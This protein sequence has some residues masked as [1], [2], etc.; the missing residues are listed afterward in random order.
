MTEQEA[1][2]EQGYTEVDPFDLSDDQSDEVTALAEATVERDALAR[3]YD[4]DAFTD[5]ALD[6]TRHAGAVIQWAA[7]RHLA[8]EAADRVIASGILAERSRVVEAAPSDTEALASVLMAWAGPWEGP[9]KPSLL[10]LLQDA[11]FSRTSQP[12]QVEVTPSDVLALVERIGN[13]VA[14]EYEEDPAL[15]D[16][17]L[18]LRTSHPV[19]VEVTTGEVEHDVDA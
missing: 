19:Q 8:V 14:A 1:R 7:R 18:Q 10:E 13:H 11:G 6:Q 4:P 16:M 2:A 9:R 5:R 17:I 3:A 12:V 15:D